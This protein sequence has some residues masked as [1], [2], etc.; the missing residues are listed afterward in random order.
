MQQYSAASLSAVI[1]LLAH[2]SEST[3]VLLLETL[4]YA[5]RP[6]APDEMHPIRPQ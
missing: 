2:T 1:P 3:L 5:V 4:E 6:N